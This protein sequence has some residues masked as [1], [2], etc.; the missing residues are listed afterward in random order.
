MVLMLCFC[1]SEH[2]L[3]SLSYTHNQPRANFRKQ[4][5]ATCM[6]SINIQ[7]TQTWLVYQV[8]YMTKVSSNV[9]VKL[10][11]E[12]VPLTESRLLVPDDV[13]L[14]FFPDLLGFSQVFRATHS[15]VEKQ[16]TSFEHRVCRL[17]S[18]WNRSEKN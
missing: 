18:C 1:E 2:K 8:S 17:K 4:N 9:H 6:L 3:M 14:S 7:V 10:H 12:S 16:E 15:C 13:S 5:G 11:E